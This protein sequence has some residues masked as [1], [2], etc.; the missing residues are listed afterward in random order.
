MESKVKK[1]N[2]INDLALFFDLLAMFD[3]EDKKINTKSNFKTGSLDTAPK[4][5]VLS[6]DNK[7]KYGA[8]RAG[9]KN[10]QK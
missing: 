9:K 4:V 2:F 1:E 5:P 10:T 6:L 7:Q 8:E 3:Y